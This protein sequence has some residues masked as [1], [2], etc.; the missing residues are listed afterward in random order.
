[1]RTHDRPAIKSEVYKANHKIVHDA[2][3]REVYGGDIRP[4][5]NEGSVGTGGRL[6]LTDAEREVGRD[7]Y[8]TAIHYRKPTR[9]VR[10]EDIIGGIG[11]LS[12]MF[13]VFVILKGMGM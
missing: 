8:T 1:M 6:F 12:L 13:L 7:P 11:C 2:L 10:T 9:R 4:N 5:G 3:R